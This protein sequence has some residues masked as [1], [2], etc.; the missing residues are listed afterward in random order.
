M[1]EADVHSRAAQNAGAHPAAA[2]DAADQS[3][4]ARPAGASV[5]VRPCGCW[6]ECSI[7]STPMVMARSAKRSW[8]PRSK[9]NRPAMTGV[10]MIV[11]AMIDVAETIRDAVVPGDVDSARVAIAPRL[12]GE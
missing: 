11:L 4:G 9:T 5:G 12:V 1:K 2:Q 3:V 8:P 7:K 6:S 10:A